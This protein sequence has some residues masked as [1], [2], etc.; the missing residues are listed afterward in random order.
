MI[1]CDPE[2]IDDFH[3]RHG[4]GALQDVPQQTFMVRV[5]MR[6][7]HEGDAGVC[8]ACAEKVLKGFQPACRSTDSDNGEVGDNRFRR[9][10]LD[11]LWGLLNWFP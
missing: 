1:G 11:Y 6:Y 4:S 5:Q 9:S 7:Q 3:H 10:I 8:R 2:L